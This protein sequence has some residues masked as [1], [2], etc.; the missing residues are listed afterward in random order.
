MK[1]KNRKQLRV[2]V[3]VNGGCAYPGHVP[4]G[5]VLEI[6]DFDNGKQADRPNGYAYGMPYCSSVTEGPS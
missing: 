4:A 5:V 3:D 1:K 6:R 2:I